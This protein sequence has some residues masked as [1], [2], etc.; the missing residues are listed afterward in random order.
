[1]SATPGSR[2]V[3]PF[4]SPSCGT[5]SFR[6]RYS[7]QPSNGAL[8]RIE[9][10]LEP[11]SNTAEKSRRLRGS[12]PTE[13]DTTQCVAVRTNTRPSNRLGYRVY[14]PLITSGFIGSFGSGRA[15][16]TSA[17]RFLGLEVLR[18]LRRP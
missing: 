6:I 3:R 1:M 9:F 4:A 17:G 10:G 15:G 5:V 14:G 13:Q 16:R 11:V 18:I 8:F 2:N 7:S 12:G